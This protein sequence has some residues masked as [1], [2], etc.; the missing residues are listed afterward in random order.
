MKLPDGEGLELLK[1]FPDR[2]FY[3]V[4]FTAH[5]DYALAAFEQGSLDYLLKP[6]ELEALSRVL[7]KITNQFLNET[8]KNAVK[9]QK[10][11]IPHNDGFLF[12]DPSEI[13]YLQAYGEYC[14]LITNEKKILISKTLKSIEEMLDQSLFIRIHRS[15]LVNKENIRFF[16]QKGKIAVEMSNGD[17]LEVSR[18]NKAMIENV[19]SGKN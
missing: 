11:A 13:V 19:L 3:V 1:Q 14:Y 8:N 7:K 16:K 15:F 6:I 12:L 18:R 4:F 9:S 10:I 2:D 17:V 5:L